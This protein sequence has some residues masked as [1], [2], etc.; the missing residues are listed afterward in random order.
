MI[1]KLHLLFFILLF[2]SVSFFHTTVFAHGCL[3]CHTKHGVKE[4]VPSIPPIN[5]LVNSKKCTITLTDA[6]KFHG[7]PCPGV[8]IAFRAIQHGINILYD[9]EIPEQ[10]DLLVF[11]RIPTRGSLDLIDLLMKG[12]KLS[13]RTWPPEGMKKSRDNFSFTVMRKSTCQAVDVKLKPER[14]PKDFFKLKKKEKDQ[15]LTSKEWDIL[16]TYMKNII[17]N[18]PTMPAKELFGNPR[19][20]KVIVWGKLLPGEMDK[21]IKQLRKKYRKRS[22]GQR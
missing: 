5:L 22:H 20:Y 17:L 18:F 16:H 6:F 4:K 10:N 11:S 21:H 1:N 19:P 8:T 13:K 15:T 9:S 3:E 7:H 14:F 2:L 12:D